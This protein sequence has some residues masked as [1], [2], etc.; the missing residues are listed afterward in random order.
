[1]QNYEGL[2]KTMKAVI[3]YS[4]TGQSRSIAEYFAEKLEYPLINIEENKETHYDDLVL[5]FPVLCQNIPD[6]IKDFLDMTE[7]VNLTVIATYGK[8]SCGNVLYEIQKK[9]KKNIVA[10]AYIPTKHSYIEDD[11][12]FLDYEKLLPI[13][14]KVKSPAEVKLP[15]L[16]KNV[17]AN[18]FP[19]TRSR[20][21]VK[22]YQTRS[23]NNCNICA[24]HCV[25]RA[26]NYGITNDE[27]IRCLR[28]VQNC[29]THALK[30]KTS[31]PMR[32]YLK[33]KRVNKVIIYV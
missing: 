31:L 9:Y 20:F 29:P 10:A 33:K 8:M 4:N 11:D 12:A 21:G 7:A 16:H 2:F 6:V 22:I 3:F 18:L 14:E 17:F 5:V 28:C 15:K 13:V 25:S 23:C 30:F 26:I 32:L 27:C 1:M 24:E 19:R